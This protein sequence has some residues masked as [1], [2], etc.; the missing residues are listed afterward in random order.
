MLNMRLRNEVYVKWWV[1][2]LLVLFTF[3]L[4]L[5]NFFLCCVI[6]PRF[7]RLIGV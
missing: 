3:H 4:S 5:F 6:F 1:K 7:W 2:V